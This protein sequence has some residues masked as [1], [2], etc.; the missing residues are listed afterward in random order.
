MR[1]LYIITQIL[2]E[3]IA[4]AAAPHPEDTK[5]LLFV[6]SHGHIITDWLTYPP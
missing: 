5:A 3:V 4:L 1:S 6:G 2:G